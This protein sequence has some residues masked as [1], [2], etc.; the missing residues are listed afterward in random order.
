MAASEISYYTK[1]FVTEYILFQRQ[2]RFPLFAGKILVQDYYKCNFIMNHINQLHVFLCYLSWF[3]GRS[4]SS[5]QF[6]FYFL[7]TLSLI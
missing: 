5:F 7:N 1:F 3:E 2:Y 4:I 6:C